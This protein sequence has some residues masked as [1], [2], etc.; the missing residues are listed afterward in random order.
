MSAA[1]G[2]PAPRA[3]ARLD[4][5]G[6]RLLVEVL[7][8]PDVQSKVEVRLPDSSRRV[9]PAR[10][11]DP[12][13]EVALD[14]LTSEAPA[15]Q[16][17]AAPAP[18]L[19]DELRA[20][21]ASARPIS[22]ALARDL[23]GL[24]SVPSGPDRYLLALDGRHIWALC[25]DR[26]LSSHEVEEQPAP[27]E[28]PRRE[29]VPRLRGQVVEVRRGASLVQRQPVP[30]AAPALPPPL[31]AAAGATS[32]KARLYGMI[33][34]HLGVAVR[35]IRPSVALLLAFP[36]S[37]KQQRIGLRTALLASV[38]IEGNRAAVQIAGA[39]GVIC[40]RLKQYRDHA[41]EWWAHLESEGAPPLREGERW[42]EE[43]DA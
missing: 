39:Q 26:V 7:S 12:E 32:V 33:H 29:R 16:R 4:H 37:S 27:A 11:L 14:L 15:A 13:N 21:L 18:R 9:V 3:L 2:C 6:A 40:Y 1:A 28:R 34:P 42:L 8:R 31:P 10:W 24:R 19:V 35:D 5:E 38:P 36:G 30:Q 43:G 22:K 17:P 20:A 23:L 25:G 41:P